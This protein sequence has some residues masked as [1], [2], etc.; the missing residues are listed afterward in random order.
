M[1]MPRAPQ[2]LLRGVELEPGLPQPPNVEVSVGRGAVLE[3]KL[4]SPSPP[5]SSPAGPRAHADVLQE[6]PR[7]EAVRTPG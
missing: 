1:W 7:A 6:G 5:P 2:V 4:G 3:L